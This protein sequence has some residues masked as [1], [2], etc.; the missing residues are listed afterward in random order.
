MAYA[1]NRES[2]KE[3]NTI[4]AY[5]VNREGVK[6]PKHNQ[7]IYSKQEWWEQHKNQLRHMQ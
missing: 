6:Q 1:V 4:M 3:T 7:D 2:E 5:V